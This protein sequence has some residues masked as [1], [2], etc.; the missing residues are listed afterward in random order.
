MIEKFDDINFNKLF[1]S[2][3]FLNN[4]LVSVLKY[5]N[6]EMGFTFN[7]LEITNNFEL[8]IPNVYLREGIYDLRIVITEIDTSPLNFVDV[9]DNVA[10]INVLP[11]DIWN[12]GK[13]KQKGQYSGFSR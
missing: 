7:E 4:D 12:S 2:I 5:V 8:E 9:I 10:T 13:T 11:G 1:V 6:D 3:E